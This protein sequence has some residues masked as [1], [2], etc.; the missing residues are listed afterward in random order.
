M[1]FSEVRSKTPNKKTTM[2]DIRDLIKEAVSYDPFWDAVEPYMIPDG[3]CGNRL[4]DQCKIVDMLMHLKIVDND[5][6]VKRDIGASLRSYQNLK[7]KMVWDQL[8]RVLRQYG[9]EFQRG[10]VTGVQLLEDESIH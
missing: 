7:Y 2:E 6:N 1:R 10:R 5:G 8:V 4:Y 3:I 9:Y